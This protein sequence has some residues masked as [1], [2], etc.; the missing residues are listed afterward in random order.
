MNVTCLY[1]QIIQIYGDLPFDLK[2]GGA[3]GQDSKNQHGCGRRSGG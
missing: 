2:Q 3:H 1:L